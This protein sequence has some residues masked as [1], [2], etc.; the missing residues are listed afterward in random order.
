M[1]EGWTA[2]AVDNFVHISAYVG[3]VFWSGHHHHRMAFSSNQNRKEFFCKLVCKQ[4]T[5]DCNQNSKSFVI[6]TNSLIINVVF[7]DHF[8]SILLKLFNYCI[9]TMNFLLVKILMRFQV[10]NT[11]SKWWQL[12]F[13]H[14]LEFLQRQQPAARSRDVGLLKNYYK[15]GF[16]FLYDSVS[17]WADLENLIKVVNW[18]K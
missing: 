1:I 11:D 16:V 6:W 17:H 12:I 14:S 9:T 8:A 7:V 4:T 5:V 2:A 3:T 10:I 18:Q 13:F 15:L